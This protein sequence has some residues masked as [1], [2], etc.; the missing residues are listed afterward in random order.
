MA[1]AESFR[2]L[3]ILLSSRWLEWGQL[4]F[5]KDA[6]EGDYKF[7]YGKDEFGKF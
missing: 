7:F 5:Y 2:N 1:S 3:N 4:K 6:S